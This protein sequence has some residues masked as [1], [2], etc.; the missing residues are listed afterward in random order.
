M[1]PRVQIRGHPGEEPRC[2]CAGGTAPW[3][4]RGLGTPPAPRS[5][6]GYWSCCCRTKGVPENDRKECHKTERREAV[7][8]ADSWKGF[9]NTK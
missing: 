6:D 4:A 8:Y 3:Q 7:D 5:V 9:I 2:T 1:P